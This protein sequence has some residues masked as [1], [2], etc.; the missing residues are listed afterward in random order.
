MLNKHT[1]VLLQFGLGLGLLV[2]LH[3]GG[4]IGESDLADM[5]L[6]YLET[7][8]T[9]KEDDDTINV[10][11][12]A[13]DFSVISNDFLRYSYSI[14][15]RVVEP[16]SMA[17]EFQINDMAETSTPIVQMRCVYSGA[18]LLHQDSLFERIIELPCKRLI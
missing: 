12:S 15:P 14:S 13:V 10:L 1:F 6:T 17:L 9:L 4:T 7:N 18:I 8:I 3:P 16:L 2:E 11:L 5:V